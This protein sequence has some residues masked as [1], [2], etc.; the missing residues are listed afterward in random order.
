MAL[1]A[2]DLLDELRQWRLA[3]APPPV[4][5]DT[6]AAVAG[7]QPSLATIRRWAD[8]P[9][10]WSLAAALALGLLAVAVVLARR[11][12]AGPQFFPDIEARERL[13]APYA[14][15]SEVQRDFGKAGRRS[16]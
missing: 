15:G 10:S 6:A 7:R 9:P 11:R 1:F 3:A 4:P 5:R 16:G 8:V 2:A 14:G 12:P 13:A